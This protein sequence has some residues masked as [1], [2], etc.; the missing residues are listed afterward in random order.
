[1]SAGLARFRCIVKWKS[2]NE[3][4]PAPSPPPA[5][6]PVVFVS[7]K[8]QDSTSISSL[9][10]ASA[11]SPLMPSNLMKKSTAAI[12]RPYHPLLRPA[13]PARVLRV[14]PSLVSSASRPEAGFAGREA[15]RCLRVFADQKMGA[16]GGNM[17]SPAT[18][19]RPRLRL[20]GAFRRRRPYVGALDGARDSAAQSRCSP[21]STPPVGCAPRTFLASGGCLVT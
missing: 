7:P 5:P 11:L 12:A 18:R 13:S 15:N 3:A 19:K 14:E 8:L 6:P 21:V 4:L 1:M 2:W 10:L 20:P 9:C 17:V 16:G